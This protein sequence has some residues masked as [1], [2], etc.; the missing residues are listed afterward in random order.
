MLES[1]LVPGFVTFFSC[2]LIRLELGILIG[3]MVN[4]CFLL[5]ASARPK[6]T[7]ERLT[8]RVCDI[9]HLAG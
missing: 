9:S 2:L 7:V 4:V 1:D 5:Y 8:V 3:I 6:V